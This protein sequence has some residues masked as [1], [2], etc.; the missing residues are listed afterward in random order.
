MYF[1]RNTNAVDLEFTVINDK[2]A[3]NYIALA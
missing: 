3:Y 2:D 1:D